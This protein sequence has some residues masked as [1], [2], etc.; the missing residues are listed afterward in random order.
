MTD[1]FAESIIP[2]TTSGSPPADA[3]AEEESMVDFID[4]GDVIPG[5]M[6]DATYYDR[7]MAYSRHKGE[8]GADPGAYREFTPEVEEDPGFFRTALAF[9]RNRN[10]GGSLL[11]EATVMFTSN[12]GDPEFDLKESLR[13]VPEEWR[14]YFV[15][16]NNSDEFEA[17][18]KHLQRE[19]ADREIIARSGFWKS[20]AYDTLAIFTDPTIRINASVAASVTSWIPHPI[21][22][23]A[24]GTGVFVGLSAL[25]RWSL[26]PVKPI[27][28]VAEEAVAGTVIGGAL[29]YVRVKFFN[30]A[31]RYPHMKRADVISETEVASRESP[32]AVGELPPPEK[33]ALTLLSLAEPVAN[34]ST[35]SY[36]AA[37]INKS[38]FLFQLTPVGKG[39]TSRFDTLAEAAQMY[40]RVNYP[41]EASRAGTGS[42]P[43]IRALMETRYAE[44]PL[45]KREYL[46]D[47]DAWTSAGNYHGMQ[48]FNSDVYYALMEG[49]EHANPHV[50]QAASRIHEMLKE[51]VDDA[52]KEGIELWEISDQEIGENYLT[53]EQASLEREELI[54]AIARGQQENPKE[55]RY[56]MRHWDTYAAA[57]DSEN[58]LKILDQA[59]LN[60][61]TRKIIDNINHKAEKAIAEAKDRRATE[62]EIAEI[63]NRREKQLANI[64]KRKALAPDRI[65][66]LS[67]SQYEHIIHSGDGE[68]YGVDFVRQPSL[69]M[70]KP[71]SVL[72]DDR[73]LAPWLVNDPLTILIST[74]KKLDFLTAQRRVLKAFGYESHQDLV[75]KLKQEHAELSKKIMTEKERVQLNRE[76]KTAM[77][78]LTDLPTIVRGQYDDTIQRYPRLALVVDIFR[79][80][81]YAKLLGSQTLSSFDDVALLVKTLGLRQTFGGFLEEI[82]AALANVPLKTLDKI[83]GTS[84]PM[85]GMATSK[86]KEEMYRLG[87]AMETVGCRELTA[88]FD[89]QSLDP[90]A[91]ASVK[92]RWG[93]ATLLALDKV[94][95][96]LSGIVNRWSGIEIWTATWK[97]IHARMTTDLLARTIL[98]DEL[99]LEDRQLLAQHRIPVRPQ[100]LERLKD[101]L[102]KHA[103]IYDGVII[104]NTPLWEDKYAKDVFGAAIVTEVNNT[105]LTP[106]AGEVPQ[107]F[108]SSWGKFFIMIRSTTFSM[109]NNVTMKWMTTG[110][111]KNVVSAILCGLGLTLLGKYIK[112]IINDNPY[113]LEKPEIYIDAVADFPFL[114]ALLE[115]LMDLERL[116]EN[117]WKRGKY[118][119]LDSLSRISPNLELPLILM[120]GARNI[121]KRIMDNNSSGPASEA[122]LRT[123]FGLLP[124]Y[125]LP[126][127]KGILN[128][129]IH[130]YSKKRGAKLMKRRLD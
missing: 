72:A 29:Q 125:T 60:Q 118:G 96:S 7:L 30:R 78:L 49:G 93:G 65:R 52:I 3:P 105:V 108:N 130:D 107:W 74:R 99:T 31:S 123:Y 103:E 45:I 17:R 6:G 58:L 110:N 64:K 39:A 116:V 66:A 95:R 71:R 12:A 106:G 80:Y 21:V 88:R 92:G 48:K 57:A 55:L 117:S 2:Q 18:K 34:A 68:R 35:P 114:K 104:P 61:V 19:L 42:F 59:N 97:M 9:L 79:Q 25:E 15:E 101:Q 76:Y 67:D 84:G 43:S 128:P 111:G 109:Y 20:L 90:Y 69:S 13:T 47:Y 127:I 22:R 33:E 23:A 94:S 24:L 62:E 82:G 91:M 4:S 26:Q 11:D 98:K 124:G 112:S 32:E 126:Y 5:L 38:K 53:L 120:M 83:S 70:M 89:S 46:E 113:D 44:I 16:S 10:V 36:R 119:A 56:F 81:N 51:S 129:M 50:R 87:V 75:D 86:M 28:E 85:F 115:P 100:D 37:G 1:F 27:E 73:L 122:L 77:Q 121:I 14:W 102:R 41:T 8:I 54:D 40:L 63:E